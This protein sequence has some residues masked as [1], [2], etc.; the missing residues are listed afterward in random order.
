MEIHLGPD[1]TKLKQN[2][3]EI[4]IEADCFICLGKNVFDGHVSG[5]S[6]KIL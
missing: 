6:I 1:G 3:V 2:S 4:K 5:D